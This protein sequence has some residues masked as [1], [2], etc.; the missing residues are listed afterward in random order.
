[1]TPFLGPSFHEKSGP[2]PPRAVQVLN[3]FSWQAWLHTKVLPGGNT[4]VVNIDETAMA[5]CMPPRKGYTL[6]CYKR[7]KRLQMAK[8]STADTRS[9]CTLV[10]SICSDAALQQHLPQ[11]I[12][13]KD[14]KLSRLENNLLMALPA[15]LCWTQGTAGWVTAANVKPLLT[16]IRRRIRLHRPACD[17]VVVWDSA[18]QH[19]HESVL[20]HL[21]RLNIHTTFV[22]G[23]LTWLL[24]SLD[25]HVFSHFKRELS[26]KQTEMRSGDVNGLMPPGAW[27]DAASEAISSC[28]VHRDW[29][30]SL[31]ANGV[32]DAT[33]PSRESIKEHFSL[34]AVVATH[35]PSSAALDELVG[36]RGGAFGPK[37]LRASLR[38]V[39]SMAAAPAGGAPPLLRLHRLHPPMGPHLAHVRPPPPLPPPAEAV[40]AGAA[41]DAGALRRTRS[42]AMY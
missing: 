35:P 18:S 38:K 19:R 3:F 7:G 33:G 29:S 41:G 42:G 37:A 20:T 9:H 25:T 30:A 17:I 14:D 16:E 22:P 34:A 12:L 5:R 6:Y 1:M 26:M 24:Q 32:V 28:L 23:G 27:I 40:P 36:A 15:P 8:I 11:F 13:T 21:N 39:A 31:R 2:G 10:A 4:V